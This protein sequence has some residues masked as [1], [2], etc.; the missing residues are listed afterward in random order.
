M[1]DPNDRTSQILRKKI[2]RTHLVLSDLQIGAE[3][4][5]DFGQE[6]VV[7]VLEHQRVALPVCEAI[8][9]FL[10]ADELVN[11]GDKARQHEHLVLNFF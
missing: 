11:L 7:R 2:Q 5:L 6:I 3:V 8:L 10:S 9:H 4:L 1:N